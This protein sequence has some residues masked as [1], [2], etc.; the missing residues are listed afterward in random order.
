MGY[1][2]LDNNKMVS[3]KSE[4]EYREYICAAMGGV[5][6]EQVMLGSYSAGGTSDFDVATKA[7]KSMIA[8]G[9][10][11]YKFAGL[12]MIN[13]NAN[14]ANEINK[15]IQEEFDRAVSILTT[16]KD[17]IEEYSKVLLEKGI[18]EDEKLAELLK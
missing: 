10:S 7:V 11:S 17:K 9:L 4:Q 6:A 18:I 5:A 8:N 16:K 3:N 15:I 12:Y 2:Q 13:T 14:I 1:T